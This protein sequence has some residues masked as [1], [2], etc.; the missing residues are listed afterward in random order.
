MQLALEDAGIVAE[1]VDYINAHA[2]STAVGDVAEA[3]AIAAV[4]GKGALVSSTKS[5]TGHELGAAGSTELIYC[6]LMMQHHFVAPNI[7]VEEIDPECGGI[8]LVANQ[9]CE[10]RIDVAAS[11]S[12]GF[13]GVNRCL[14]VTRHSS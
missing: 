14:V 10:T 8:N 7:N 5:M 12:F 2:S 9:A 1:Q 11:N 13:G 4:F 3:R 6:L